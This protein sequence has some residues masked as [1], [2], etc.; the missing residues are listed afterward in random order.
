M[1]IFCLY[2][3]LLL[4]SGVSFAQGTGSIFAPMV[5]EGHRS[6]QYRMVVDPNDD[7]NEVGFAQRLHYQASID[8][9]FRWRLIGQTRKTNDSDF[10][11]DF[12]QAEL[13]WDLSED[14]QPYRTGLRFDV[15]VRDEDRPNQLGLH[16]TNQYNFGNDW[17]ARGILMT[18]VQVGNNA[19]SG[20]T[21]QTRWRV[22]KRLEQGQTL[23]AEFYNNYGNSRDFGDFND[24]NHSIG[25]IYVKSL[26]S[27]WSVLSSALFGLSDQAADTE[28][29]LWFTKKI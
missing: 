25:P 20:V 23:G 8:G 29:K 10:D 16:W 18:S 14:E 27:G 17:H 26:G 6:F 28:L 22:A 13:S 19:A 3:V 9:D 15:R 24:Q 1:F 11:F 12:V 4:F 21:I 7:M 2:F 5:N